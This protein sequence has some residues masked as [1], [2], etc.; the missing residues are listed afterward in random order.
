MDEA[1]RRRSMKVELIYITPDPEAHIGE[2][3]AECYD[4]KT[5]RESCIKRAAHCVDSGHLATLR[6]AYATVRITGISRVCS[7]QIVRVAHAGILQRSQRY[8][9]ETAVEFVRPPSVVALPDDLQKRW[10]RVNHEGEALYLEAIA[11]GMKKEDA[12]YILPQGC[13]TS[14]RM[15][16]NFQMWLD[17]LGNRTTKH[18]QWE[19]RD[20]AIETKRLLAE[21]AP[22]IFGG[23][24]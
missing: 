14:L 9:K 2:Q 6:F 10:H 3:A 20:V 21:H 12:R 17:L 18:A 16:G 11:A 7:H 8:V 1:G 24:A 23:A 13:T 15:T 19:V 5:D 22:G 4:S